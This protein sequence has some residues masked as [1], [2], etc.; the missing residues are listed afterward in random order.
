VVVVADFRL[1]AGAPIS[2]SAGGSAVAA[3]AY[4]SRSCIRDHRTGEVH[5]YREPLVSPVLD[6]SDHMRRVGDHAHGQGG[7]AVLYSDLWAIAER[8][9][10][11]ENF[12]PVWNDA[13]AAERRVDAQ[14]ATPYVLNLP[15]EASLKDWIEDVREYAWHKWLRHG[16]IVQVAIHSPEP[17]HDARNFHAHFLV[18]S[19]PIDEDGN[20]KPTKY[21]EQHA[22]FL[23]KHENTK[24]DRGAWAAIVNRRLARLGVE[25]VDHRSYAEQGI[26]RK[27]RQRLSR[28]AWEAQHS[29][30]NGREPDPPQPSATPTPQ[31]FR[32][33]AALHQR[34]AAVAQRLTGRDQPAAPEP[35]ETPQARHERLVREAFERL[36]ADKV[37]SRARDLTLDDLAI[38]LSPKYLAAS[39]ELSAL[40]TQRAEL[41]TSVKRL[42]V[43]REVYTHRGDERRRELGLIRAGLHD[44]RWNP[45]S[46]F[47]DAFRDRELSEWQR[48]QRGTEKVLPKE[49]RNLELVTARITRVSRRMERAYQ[50]IRPKA[51]AELS[52]LQAVVAGAEQIITAHVDPIMGR[53]RGLAARA[54][55]ERRLTPADAELLKQE[56]P[57]SPPPP[58]RTT[59]V[60]PRSGAAA[61]KLR[62]LAELA[63]Q[64]VEIE[65]CIADRAVHRRSR[66]RTGAR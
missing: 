59:D 14:V 61:E 43:N 58:P 35:E 46:A 10:G 13:Q 27:P 42:R 45:R 60:G 47:R 56:A 19:R 16:F 7:Q 31:R 32:G 3:S 37:A 40:H 30:S 34:V 23:H 15:H 54:L 55:R 4:I 18:S 11:E 1:H 52:R 49:A 48:R 51:E 44:R 57:P 22:S 65:R 20:F 26:D 64:R 17:G 63:R 28:K 8:R 2:F 29:N 66:T 9:R 50:T 33:I 6:A 53:T 12:S 5:D 62:K 41:E 21:H 38:R 24:E 39:A 36:S 25:P